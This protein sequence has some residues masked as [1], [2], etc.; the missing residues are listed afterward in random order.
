VRLHLEDA[1]HL[2]E[3]DVLPPSQTDDLVPRGEDLEVDAH[4]IELVDG[5]TASSR[6]EFCC[7]AGDEGEGGEVEED[8][9]LGGGEE[10]DVKVFKRGVDEADTGRL[11]DGVFGGGRDE[12]GE[13]GEEGLEARSG[14]T[15]ELA[16]K[17]RCP[18][19]TR[20]DGGN[21]GQQRGPRSVF[22]CAGGHRPLLRLVLCPPTS[23]PF[24]VHG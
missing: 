21:K 24:R 6:C 13:G 23:L 16:G 3:V 2:L 7:D 22:V 17:E 4:N 10:E 1:P 11:D 12:A 14:K 9:G 5:S 15:H 8:V 20:R 19:V 18:T